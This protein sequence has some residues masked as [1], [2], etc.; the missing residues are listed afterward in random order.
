MREFSRLFRQKS[1]KDLSFSEY[2]KKIT[3][4]LF[5]TSG[6]VAR[7]YNLCRSHRVRQRFMVVQFNTEHFAHNVESRWPDIP[8]LTRNLH[9]A[10]KFLLRNFDVRHATACMQNS[11]I[12][13]RVVGDQIFRVL[14]EF[15]Y[16][17]PDLG[18]HRPR[19]YLVPRK[20]M[21][22]CKLEMLKGWAY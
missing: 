7:N 17:G 16:L 13:R 6:S 2:E 11:A 12:K 21:D 20:S 14:N 8:S 4:G 3:R 15:L 18:E 19:F 9:R 10:D 5:W 22:I 1:D